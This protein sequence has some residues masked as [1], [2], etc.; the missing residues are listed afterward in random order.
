[1]TTKT[2]DDCPTCGGTGRRVTGYFERV[3][4]E[5]CCGRG[6]VTEVHAQRIREREQSRA[7]GK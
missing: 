4:C 3:R 7:E 1:M 5:T 2:W 6:L